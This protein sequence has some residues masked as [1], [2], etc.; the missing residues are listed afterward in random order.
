MHRIINDLANKT[1]TLGGVTIGSAGVGTASGAI[2]H[3]IIGRILIS[4]DLLSLLQYGAYTVSIIV[5][6]LTIITWCRKNNKERK[7]K[8]LEEEKE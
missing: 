1:I 2:N 8:K 5:G 6:I 4:T 7:L 3:S